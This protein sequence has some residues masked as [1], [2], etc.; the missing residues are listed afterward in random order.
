MRA[1]ARVAPTYLACK[2]YVK[3]RT[4][5]LNYDSCD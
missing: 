1:T 3:E 4:V 2:Q 5:C